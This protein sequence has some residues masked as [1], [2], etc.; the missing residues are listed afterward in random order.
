[1]TTVQEVAVAYSTKGAKAAARSDQKV[2][3]SITKTAKRARKESGTISRWM[4]RHKSAISAIGAATAGALGAIIS[5]SPTMRAELSA[6]RT[7]FSM[8][9]DTVMRDVLPSGGGLADL[10][11]KLQGAY[12][13]LHPAIRTVA[14]AAMVFAGVLGGLIAV[15]AAVIAAIGAKV[16]LIAGALLLAL[17][18]VGAAIGAAATAWQENWFGIRETTMQVVNRIIDVVETGLEFLRTKILEPLLQKAREVWSI[19]GQ[20]LRAEARRTWDVVR[21][22]IESGLDFVLKWIRTFVDA[23]RDFWEDW[24]DDIMATARFLF[25]FLK[26]SLASAFDFI[27]TTIRVVLAAIRGDWDEAWELI[28]E[29]FDRQADRIG[30]IAEDFTSTVRDKIEALVDA[31]RDWGQDLIDELVDGIESKLSSVRSAVSSVD[32]AVK[33]RLSYDIRANDRQAQT[34]GQDLLEEMAKGAQRGMPELEAVLETPR[35]AAGAGAGGQGGGGSVVIEEGAIQI[36]GS[37]SPRQ[38]AERTVDEI[39]TQLQ[40]KFGQRR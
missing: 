11:F 30:E 9:A 34:W 24:G 6:V 33:S 4:E 17:A 21:E 36:D 35:P 23:A 3:E 16:A 7:A 10:A 19:H 18:L 5:A 14:S 31:A 37:G 32:D 29:F 39:S 8:F 20:E 15:V 13:D 40:D 1:M 28:V 38:T 27:L 26:T 2:R 25:K 22:R 12:T